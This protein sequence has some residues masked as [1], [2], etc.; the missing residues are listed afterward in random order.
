MDQAQIGQ[1]L[2]RGNRSFV[3]QVKLGWRIGIIKAMVTDR[4]PND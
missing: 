3:L 1:P 4:G 2:E